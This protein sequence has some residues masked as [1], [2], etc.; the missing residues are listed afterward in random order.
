MRYGNGAVQW[1]T[2]GR[3]SRVVHA[4]IAQGPARVRSLR[5][6]TCRLCTR[7]PPA[8]LHEEMW[9]V[10][11]EGGDA[12]L[13]QLWV[14]LPPSAKF[15]APRVQLLT[16]RSGSIAEVVREG[17][18]P[19]RCAAIAQT[20]LQGG[21]VT[22]R[23][24]AGTPPDAGAGADAGKAAGAVDATAGAVGAQTYT[25]MKIEHVELRGRD[26]AYTLPLPDGWTCIVYV[27]RGRVSSGGAVAE[28]HETLYMS[29]HGGEC[30]QL[31][32][33]ADGESDVLI[34][35]GEPIGAPVVA[36]GTMVMSTQAQ[37]NQAVSDYQRGEFG[38]PW[39]HTLSDDEWQSQCDAVVAAR[40]RRGSSAQP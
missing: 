27:R 40:A 33:G 21:S 39:D 7:S 13:Y 17:Q 30:L 18:T 19:V 32:N 10:D 12:E 22:V 36:S 24:L 20:E 25:P 26:A 34:L 4:R 6:P 38:I 35:A 16:Q 15:V 23:T 5:D 1:M 31:A 9:D 2:A 37:V 11:A 28:M 8:V 29:R 14:N 3:G